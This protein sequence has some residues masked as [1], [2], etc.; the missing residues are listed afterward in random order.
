MH[1][2][3][4]AGGIYVENLKPQ[5]HDDSSKFREI[6]KISVRELGI[7]AYREIIYI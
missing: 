3:M 2:M 4:M 7:Q 5:R 1:D 6:W